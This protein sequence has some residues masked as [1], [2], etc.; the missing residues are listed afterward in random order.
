MEGSRGIGRSIRLLAS[1]LGLISLATSLALAQ[2]IGRYAPQEIPNREGA[3]RLPNEEAPVF[4]DTEVIIDK[5]RGIV[6]LDDAASVVEKADATGVEVRGALGLLDTYDFQ[7]IAEAYLDKPA[8]MRTLNE[9][10]RDV[11]V[12]YRRNGQPVVDVSLP[13]QDV[14]NGVVQVVVTEGVVGRVRVENARYFNPCM[15][16]RQVRTQPGTYIDESIL[17]EDLFW[18][19]QNPFREVDLSIEPG[20]GFGETDVVFTVNDR[21]PVRVYTGY[22]DTGTRFTALERLLFGANWGNAFWSDDRVGYQYTASPNFRQLQSHSGIYEMPLLNRDTI[23]V[24]GSYGRVAGVL[25]PFDQ[26]GEAW[27]TSI[28]YHWQRCQRHTGVTKYW[29]FGFDFKRTNTNLDFGGGQ[30]FGNNADIAQLVVG[31]HLDVT[32]PCESLACGFDTYIGLSGMT[33]A[34]NYTD[35]QTVRAL[36]DP[37]F[38][39]TQ[40]YLDYKRW[41]AGD[42]ML[43]ARLTGQLASHNMLPS[44]TMAFGGYYSI[45]GYDMYFFSGD[46]G[47]VANFELYTPEICPGLGRCCDERL[48]ALTFVDMGNVWVHTKVTPTDPNGNFLASIGVGLRYTL[49]NRVSLRADY[50][51]QIKRYPLDPTSGGRFHVGA[52]LSY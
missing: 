15:L 33:S 47:Y 25:P 45:R 20:A 52:V 17:L 19:N 48:R 5:L 40:A 32:S 6:F 21:L 39:Y 22:E 26:T 50:A 42:W 44:E 27:Q 10:A 34:N 36:S 1:A 29:A 51:R 30:V 37:N 3:V 7:S 43:R 38:I 9:L 35:Y 41:T 2:D 23:L 4:G 12:Y 46:S 31:Y 13:E 11:I 18:L 16:T 14:S 49:T 28:R 24:Y 8:S